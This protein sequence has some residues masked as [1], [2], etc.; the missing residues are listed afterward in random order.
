MIRGSAAWPS[1]ACVLLAFDCDRN[2]AGE[3]A[4]AWW[5]QTL[6]NAVRWRPLLHDVNAM[7]VGGVNVRTWAAA[8]IEYAVQII[9]T[10]T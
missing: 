4:A 10:R 1:A 2:G 9:N 6:P 5:L 3:Q 8:G 7:H